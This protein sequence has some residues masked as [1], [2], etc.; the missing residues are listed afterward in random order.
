MRKCMEIYQRN[1]TTHIYTLTKK[2]KRIMQY[3]QYIK[4]QIYTII[5]ALIKIGRKKEAVQLIYF[6]MKC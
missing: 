5:Y 1:K 2:N 4:I 3:I 6:Q